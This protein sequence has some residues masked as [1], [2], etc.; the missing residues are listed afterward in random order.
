LIFV[1]VGNSTQSFGRLLDSVDTMAGHGLFNGEP[2]FIQSGNNPDFEPRF[3]KHN[4]FMSMEEFTDYINNS[5]LVICHAGAGTLIHILKAGKVP[6][7]M[8]RQKKYDEHVDDH[9]L[10]LVKA[11]LEE[12]RVIVAFETEDLPF[13]IIEA[14][15]RQATDTAIRIPPMLEIVRKAIQELIESH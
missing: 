13:A 15:K 12:K 14:R 4:P 9:Q 5:S 11:L 3:C 8:P 2:I 7:V 6:L 1:T 10:E